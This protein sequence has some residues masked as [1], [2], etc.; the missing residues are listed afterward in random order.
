MSDNIDDIIRKIRSNSKTENEILA[1]ELK[2]RLSSEQ[3][4]TLDKLLSD[5]ELMK[6]MMSSDEVKRLMEKL[7]GDRN[8]H[9]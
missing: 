8:G 3:T 5:K 2:S 6:K 9:K 7:G 1:N 4:K